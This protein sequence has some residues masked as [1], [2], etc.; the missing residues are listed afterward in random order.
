MYGE[1]RVS[2]NI[3]S[4]LEDS[5]INKE[6]VNKSQGVKMVKIRSKM[7]FILFAKTAFYG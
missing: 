1:T 2:T 6:T 7:V 4:M 3:E 5:I